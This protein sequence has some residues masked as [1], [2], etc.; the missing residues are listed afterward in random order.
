MI[1]HLFITGLLTMSLMSCQTQKIASSDPEAA[2]T[3]VNSQKNSEYIVLKEGE[4]K[5]LDQQQM[6]IA[7]KK[8]TE[9]SRCPEGANCAWEGVA[10][11]EIELMGVYTRPKTVLLSTQSNAQRGYVENFDF[12][13]YRF[14]LTEITPEP[15]T[16]RPA[17]ENRGEYVLKLK[18][19]QLSK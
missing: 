8:V 4:R 7:F 5:F 13:G 10:T 3:H 19:S 6:N 2:E 9:D 18:V 15:T 16:R 14:T 1:N 11:V 17:E 12:A